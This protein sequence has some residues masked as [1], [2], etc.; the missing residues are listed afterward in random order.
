MPLLFYFLLWSKKNQIYDVDLQFVEG[1][2]RSMWNR[3][4]KLES[5][6]KS[7]DDVAKDQEECKVKPLK[8]VLAEDSFDEG[9]T[10]TAEQQNEFAKSY[11]QNFYN[12]LLED[13]T[14][15]PPE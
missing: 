10:G 15:F 4:K 13:K 7:S 8:E 5:I 3:K 11:F 9:Q 2:L 6:K 1:N 14:F 12:E